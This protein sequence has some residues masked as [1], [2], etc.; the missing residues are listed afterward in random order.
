MRIFL[1]LLEPTTNGRLTRKNKGSTSSQTVST[2]L[3]NING[4]GTI[5]AIGSSKANPDTGTFTL[6]TSGSI[7]INPTT[8]TFSGTLGQVIYKIWTYSGAVNAS[9]S[10]TSFQTTAITSVMLIDLP[11]TDITV[12]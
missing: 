9:V 10:L 7:T 1:G 5:I 11:S 8:K 3:A 6:S 2:S 4:E 12:V